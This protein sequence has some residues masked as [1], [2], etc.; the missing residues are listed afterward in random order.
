MQ[1][2]AGELRRLASYSCNVGPLWRSL[3]RSLLA[4]IALLSS[5]RPC[6]TARRRAKGR[7]RLP[8]YSPAR[9]SGPWRG[10]QDSKHSRLLAARGAA[11][12]RASGV[13][14]RGAVRAQCCVGARGAAGGAR[15]DLAEAR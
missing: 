1:R 11:A 5:A 2:G 10:R 6:D 14:S 7:Q 12:W 15:D 9:R 8:G 13:P 4:R 3:A